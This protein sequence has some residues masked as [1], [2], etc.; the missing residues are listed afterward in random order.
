MSLNIQTAN[1]LLE[2]SAKV[3]K[4]KVIEALGYEPAN[5]THVKDNIVHIT[6]EER[7]NWNNKFDGT[8]ADLE[9][10]PNITEDESGNF[11]IADGNGNAIMQVDS[12]GVTTT[13]VNTK[14][15]ALNGEDLGSRLDSLESI[16]LPNILDNET[17][18]LAIADGDGNT[19]V[20][21]DANGITTTG[22]SAKTLSLNGEDIGEKF[23]AHIDDSVSHVT[24]EER[25]A[26][27]N[28]S[29]FSGDY[30][31]LNNKPN[32]LDDNSAEFSISDVNN[33]VIFRVDTNGVQ[34]TSIHTDTLVLANEDIGIKINNKADRATTLEGYGITDAASKAYVDTLIE[35][36][37]TEG[38]ADAIAKVKEDV[39][40]LDN[41]GTTAKTDLVTVI[42]EVRNSV[43]A[44][45][46]AA[47]V[48]M[49]TNTTTEGALK[50]YT[51]KQGENVVGTIDIP[52][53]MVVESGEVVV[54]PEGQD[55]G[56]YIKL[57]LAN[58]TEPLYINV[59]TLV[60]IY[61]A[62]T[63]ATQV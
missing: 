31:D 14:S 57:V 1:G 11:V 8:Y 24:S 10:S 26:W 38:T 42:N 16:S 5:E 60:D 43:S 12:D 53:D 2:I 20:K 15:I 36:L 48:T 35:G 45:G 19:I 41:L 29:D 4:N 13:N 46:T 22:V 59:G 50:S 32:V 55:A 62:K 39:G 51:I 27:N 9:G 47:A 63:E 28:K 58:V 44:G 34:T 6:S 7:E 33:N 3:T 17:G 54:N 56:T 61:K 30:N 40:S 37:T 49:D 23:D 18:D 21:V 25:T 52:K